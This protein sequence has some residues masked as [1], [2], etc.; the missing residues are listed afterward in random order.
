MLDSP[1]CCK[2]QQGIVQQNVVEMRNQTW[3]FGA[4]L[5]VVNITTAFDTTR[6][7]DS[8]P[9][10]QTRKAGLMAALSAKAQ[11]GQVVIVDTLF[12]P[13]A[14]MRAVFR[15]V[16][17]ANIDSIKAVDKYRVPQQWLRRSIQGPLGRD[18]GLFGVVHSSGK[19]IQ[20]YFPDDVII[21]NI[22]RKLDD[23][24]VDYAQLLYKTG[25]RAACDSSA[26]R[27]VCSQLCSYCGPPVA[28]WSAENMS[29]T[30]G[31]QTC[32]VDEAAALCLPLCAD[33][34]CIAG[35]FVNQVQKLLPSDWDAPPLTVTSANSIVESLNVRT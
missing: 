7:W 20:S 35:Y 5:R 22:V 4:L 32:S 25:A 3:K 27:A 33:Y 11:A 23:Q 8:Q 24:G 28:A 29:L 31:F 6:R 26:C 10:V 1:F 2:L 14:D 13:H 16:L 30:A 17:K 21:D 9:R 18:P 19:Y 34:R 15:K 12:P